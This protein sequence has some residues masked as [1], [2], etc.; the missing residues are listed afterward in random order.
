MPVLCT[1]AKPMQEY[2]GLSDSVLL[3]VHLNVVDLNGMPASGCPFGSVLR[4]HGCASQMRDKVNRSGRAKSDSLLSDD[5][6]T[7]QRPRR[8]ILDVEK[9]ETQPLAGV[10]SQGR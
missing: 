9:T 2:Q 10:Q 5:S 4:C 3:V 8:S 1:T 7:R 6:A